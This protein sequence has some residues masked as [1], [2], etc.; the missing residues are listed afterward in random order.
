[1]TP[2]HRLRKRWNLRPK[3]AKLRETTMY[4]HAAKLS[5]L[6]EDDILPVDLGDTS[7]VLYRSGSSVRACQRYCPHQHSDLSEGLVSRGFLIC[8]AHGWRFDA[9]T[10]VHEISKQTCLATYQ[11]K[12]E[13]EDILVDTTPIR[14]GDAP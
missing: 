7:I 4:Q 6:G 14:H 2:P 5:E 13:G 9:D 3:Q 1:M 8:S 11:V 12:V 10:G